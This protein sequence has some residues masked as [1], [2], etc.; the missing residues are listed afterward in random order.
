MKPLTSRSSLV[1][2]GL[3]VG[4]GIAGL[5]CSVGVAPDA[6]ADDPV[7][8]QGRTIYIESCMNCHG[9]AGGGGRGSKLNEGRVLEAYPDPADQ[10]AV[11]A[12]GAEAMP[13][14]DEKLTTDEIDAVVRYT[15]EVLAA[16]SAR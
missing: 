5:G 8:V 1:G 13:G 12:V 15:R 2:I 10:T 14:F 4:L 11:V 3:V 9:S 6:P 7:L 16:R